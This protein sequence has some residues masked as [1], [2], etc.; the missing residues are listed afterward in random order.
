MPTL[1][2]VAY[3][4]AGENAR[5]PSQPHL[6]RAVSTAYYAAFH[7]LAGD[8]ADQL[9]GAGAARRSADWL[10]VFRA[11]DH[12][13]ARTIAS[14]AKSFDLPPEIEVFAEALLNLQRERYRA[15]YDPSSRY[16]REAVLALIEEAEQAI[17]ALRRAPR[18]HRRAFAVQLCFRR[19]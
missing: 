1:I 13:A 3:S 15:D 4:L 19:R 17:A 12:A 10:Q 7:A 2:D 16:S 8:C 9:I 6:R 5:R 11:V 18:L 14:Q